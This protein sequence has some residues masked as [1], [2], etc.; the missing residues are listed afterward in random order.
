[1]VETDAGNNGD[2]LVH[3]VGRIQTPAHSHFQN[4]ELHAIAKVSERHGR[5]HFEIS[6]RIK[7]SRRVARSSRN[8]RV[9]LGQIL[10]GYFGAANPESF[11]KTLQVRG[12]VH[13]GNVLTKDSG[14][15]A[16]KY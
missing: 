6:R 9:D 8:L 12:S 15:A 7:E 4:R 13:T 1:M 14:L 10:V 16:P 2:V 3:D 5:R 11:V